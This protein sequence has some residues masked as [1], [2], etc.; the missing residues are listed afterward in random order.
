[1]TVGQTI[2][3]ISLILKKKGIEET[4]LEAR[5]MLSNLLRTNNTKLYLSCQKE[6]DLSQMMILHEMIRRRIKREPIQYIIGECDF[7]D[8]TFYI[9]RGV[10][11]PRSETELLVLKARDFILEHHSKVV[12]DIGT[13]CGAIALSLAKLIPDLSVY[14]SDIA[15][16]NTVRVNRRLL[17]VKDKVH[18]LSGSL[19]EPYDGLPKADLIVSN[20]PYIPS[21]Q[22]SFLEPEVR[23]FEPRESLDGGKDGLTFIRRL[24]SEAQFYLKSKGALMFE[25]GHGEWKEVKKIARC[26]FRNVDLVFDYNQRE[27]IC[28]CVSE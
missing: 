18:L 5:Y 27:R 25:I 10:F 13:G 19:F 3:W 15:D 24:L 26:N 21:N 1:M 7:L 4:D 8:Y 23:D 22:I 14:A 6:V 11:I 17:G 28:I 20:P 9:E 16:L 12:Y 2:G